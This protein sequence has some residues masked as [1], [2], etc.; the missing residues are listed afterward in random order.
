MLYEVSFIRTLFII[1]IV[2]FAIR[3]FTKYILPYFVKKG[4]KNMQEKMHDQ[5]REQQR[6]ERKEGEV[7]IEKNQE[8]KKNS[9]PD[10]GEYVDFEEVD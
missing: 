8:D 4:I 6:S 3:L 7:T 10:E 1:A 2:Y 9:H 5:Y